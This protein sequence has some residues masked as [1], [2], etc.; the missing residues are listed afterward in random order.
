[1]IYNLVYQTKGIDMVKKSSEYSPSFYERCI[2][3]SIISMTSNKNK[4]FQ[5]NDKIA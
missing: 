4:F 3:H 1:M 2:L 5:T